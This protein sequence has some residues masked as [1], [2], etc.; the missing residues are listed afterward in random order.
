MSRPWKAK[1]TS[2]PAW[3]RS[4]R[5]CE[6]SDRRL[7]RSHATSSPLH[8]PLNSASAALATAGPASDLF[9]IVSSTS[10]PNVGPKSKTAVKHSSSPR[11]IG[12][13]KERARAHG[14][15]L[16]KTVQKTQVNERTL[17]VS[18]LRQAHARLEQGNELI[19]QRLGAGAQLVE[20]RS[21]IIDVPTRARGAR[22]APAQRTPQRDGQVPAPRN[23]HA[24]GRH[25]LA[26]A[27]AKRGGGAGA[28]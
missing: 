21:S 3:D 5:T 11:G 4:C 26:P 8:A 15:G 10:R 7:Q 24:P 28:D 25:V 6:H 9:T 18:R 19:A 27:A 14:G 16:A 22:A 20:Q 12:L 1:G 2:M 17:H 13:A 23:P